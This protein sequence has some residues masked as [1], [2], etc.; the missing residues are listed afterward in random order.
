MT[1][2]HITPAYSDVKPSMHYVYV[3]VRAS[4]GEPFY[5][6]LGKNQRGWVSS[7]NGRGVFWSRVA[8]KNGV[9]IEIAQDGMSLDGARLLEMWLIA[10]FR[11]RGIMLVNMTDGGEG[12][13]GYKHSLESSLKMSAARIGNKNCKG[14]KYSKETLDRM[15]K[16]AQGKKSRLD[17]KIRKFTHESGDTFT[18]TRSEFYEKYGLDRSKVAMVINGH[19]KS[20]G[21]WRIAEDL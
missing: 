9:K 2:I 6:G 21:G 13:Y 12:S 18:G 17:K 11:N 7:E 20:T 3:H 14:R 15:S 4:T 5:V 8:R 1:K 19:R 16:S 10:K